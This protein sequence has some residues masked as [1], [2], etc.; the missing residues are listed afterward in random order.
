MVWY[1]HKDQFNS[2]GQ[3][4]STTM[5]KSFLSKPPFQWGE[6][7]L[8]TAVLEQLDTQM[9]KVTLDA[10]CTSHAK[11]NLKW[12]INLPIKVKTI[13]VLEKIENHH[14]PEVGKA[15]LGA[16]KYIN[17]KEKKYLI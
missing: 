3:Q 8:S 15:F 10:H 16:T 6:D 7:R 4:S 13:K 9:G 1:W 12:T 17:L 11:I 14:K 2:T 5:A